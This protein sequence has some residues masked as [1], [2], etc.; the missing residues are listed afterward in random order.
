MK[1]D[2]VPGLDS[3]LAAAV[4]ERDRSVISMVRD[5]IAQRR[6]RLAWQ[7]VVS[8]NDHTRVAFHEGLM[9]VLDETGRIIPARDFM[10]VVEATE[11]GRLIDCAALEMGLRTLLRYPLARVS[12][13]MSAR[14]IG[15]P[16]WLRLL[17]RALASYPTVG[18]RLILEIT[19]ASAMQVPELVVT[20]MDEMQAAGIA[21]ALD[22]FGA[23]QTAFRYFR[24]FFFDILKIDGQFSAGICRNADNQA[25]MHALLSIGHHFDMLTVAESVETPQD[26][27][28]LRGAG[29]GGLQGFLFGAP[30]VQPPWSVE[31][32]KA[33]RSA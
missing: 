4:S 12:V 18:E 20:F 26:A 16:R 5:A 2:I 28:W 14:S 30:T 11:L 6:L 21:F 8:A 23:G 22:D 31:D 7:P 33:R 9:R 13:N 19:E 27:E 25:L 3:P 15:Y 32:G 1:N 10:P 24:E 29:L 17:R